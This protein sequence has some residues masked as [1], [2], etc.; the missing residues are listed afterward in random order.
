MLNQDQIDI[1]RETLAAL[2][3]KERR[4]RTQGGVDKYGQ[5]IGAV[6]VAD[7]I[8]TPSVPNAPS[9]D[10]PE[11]RVRV[12]TKPPEEGPYARV[13]Q[14]LKPWYSPDPK[15]THPN[16]SKYTTS[17]NMGGIQPDGSIVGFVRTDALV[18]MQGNPTNPEK[19]AEIKKEIDEFGM[20]EPVV[21]I[22]N[23]KSGL[24]YVG[25]GNHRVQ[26]AQELGMPWIPVRVSVSRYEWSEEDIEYLKKDGGEP[27]DS[28]KRW[29]DSPWTGG[30]NE[31]YWPTEM[32]PQFLF[33]DKDVYSEDEVE[34]SP[35][36]EPTAVEV[37]EESLDEQSDQGLEE[38]ATEEDG[39]LTFPGMPEPIRREFIGIERSDKGISEFDLSNV[40]GVV[41]PYKPRPIRIKDVIKHEGRDKERLEIQAMEEYSERNVAYADPKY[42]Q[43]GLQLSQ[44]FEQYE[45]NWLSPDKDSAKVLTKIAVNEQI[46][47]RMLD[48]MEADP[49]FRGWVE[50]FPYEQDFTVAK[51]NAIFNARNYGANGSEFRRLFVKDLDL[52]KDISLDDAVKAFVLES[53]GEFEHEEDKISAL[54]T[55]KEKFVN[56]PPEEVWFIG[57]NKKL[58]SIDR[59]GPEEVIGHIVKTNNGEYK[60][61]RYSEITPEAKKRVVTKERARKVLEG[62]VHIDEYGNPTIISSTYLANRPELLDQFSYSEVTMRMLVR[63]QVDKWAHT[64]AD[65][66]KDSIAMQYA[67]LEVFGLDDV[68]DTGHFGSWWGADS[69]EQLAPFREV[70]AKAVYENTQDYFRENGIEYVYGYRG[71]KWDMGQIPDW[72]T[73]G[74]A[75]DLES[76]IQEAIDNAL[77]EYVE[78]YLYENEDE[79]KQRINETVEENFQL[80]KRRDDYYDDAEFDPDEAT[81]EQLE[82]WDASKIEDFLETYYEETESRVNEDYEQYARDEF[83][84]EGAEDE[85]RAGFD[86]EQYKP[87]GE[88]ITVVSQPLSSWSTN[89]GTADDFGSGEG[90]YGIVVSGK[91]PV[92]R[93]FCTSVTGLGCLNEGE[94]VVLGDL[95]D[96]YVE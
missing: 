80:W 50:N 86:I 10:K 38:F 51:N 90:Q 95:D 41:R 49:E 32:H 47:R 89:R 24:M 67:A 60:I 22:F 34:E 28:G 23:P 6:I 31:A 70:F 37:L 30:L 81:E 29:D 35:E 42:K 85:I 43:N 1:L 18:G 92:E 20:K 71:M 82:E 36:P 64:S 3:A 77:E 57:K 87:S 17:P 19:V 25:D 55:W 27:R 46:A 21:V 76:E 7:G 93:I 66:D 45:G 79:I 69:V 4:V 26:A 72:A 11:R 39:Q 44:A 2:E 40:D 53:V 74:N 62:T 88:L 65:S 48:H 78:N 8:G 52:H 75:N 83:Y 96:L 59:F 68:S 91:I 9:A 5:P 16:V 54:E 94:F 61:A 63:A 33:A 73:N 84:N 12:G 13:D 14:P 58:S 15:V 56:A